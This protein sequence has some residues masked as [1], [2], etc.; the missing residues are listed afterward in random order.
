MSSYYLPHKEMTDLLDSILAMF[1]FDT[2][3]GETKWY[4]VS[5]INELGA[6]WLRDNYIARLV[7]TIDGRRLEDD[8]EIGRQT[9][10]DEKPVKTIVRMLKQFNLN[11]VSNEDAFTKR[12][13]IS[14]KLFFKMRPY[15]ALRKDHQGRVSNTLLSKPML[16]KPIKT[17]IGQVYLLQ[18]GHREVYKIGYTGI[19]DV[20]Q[21]VISLQTSNP[22][23]ISIVHTVPTNHASR[24]EKELHQRFEARRIRGE[25]FE[26]TPEDVEYIKSL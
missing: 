4:T 18:V 26:L 3:T 9:K 13:G 16:A 20:A 19:D 17:I 5:E 22:D 1:E 23:V 25:W 15:V 11:L 14:S 6:H 12:Y 8:D 7:D 21:R 2:G 24:L 10:L